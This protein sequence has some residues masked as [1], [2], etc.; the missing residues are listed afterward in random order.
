MLMLMLRVLYPSGFGFPS[1]LV[2]HH[3]CPVNSSFLTCFPHHQALW[4]ICTRLYLGTSF[5]TSSSLI[6]SLQSNLMDVFFRKDTPDEVKDTSSHLHCSR[7][8][9]IRVIITTRIF[10][11][12]CPE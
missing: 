6:Y 4:C 7:H 9:S 2:M 11:S 3:T 12:A 1:L 5:P 8:L 10:I